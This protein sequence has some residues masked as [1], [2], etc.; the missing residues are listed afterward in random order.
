MV[1]RMS[2]VLR[3]RTAEHVILRSLH[4]TRV[5]PAFTS[6]SEPGGDDEG[7][8]WEVRQRHQPL[9]EMRCRR[10][11]RDNVGTYD[12]RLRIVRSLHFIYIRTV[13]K[14]PAAPTTPME[15][16]SAPGWLPIQAHPHLPFAFATTMLNYLL[17]VSS[18]S[19][20]AHVANL[21]LSVRRHAAR[22]PSMTSF[23]LLVQPASDYNIPGHSE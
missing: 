8:D 21:A 4:S 10:S 16:S 11:I 3:A 13:V 18:K 23:T 15:N 12:R 1:Y 14:K 2:K 5:N 17:R 6:L 22:P 20:S 7:M 9:V 19:T